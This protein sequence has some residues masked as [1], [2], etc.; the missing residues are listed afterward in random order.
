[1]S[2]SIRRLEEWYARHC[3]GDWEHEDGVDIG[4]LD[5]PGWTVDINIGATELEGVAFDEVVEDRTPDDWIRCR[6][7]GS[8]WQGRGGARNLDEL[9]AIFLAWAEAH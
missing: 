3:D 8:V 9:L 7:E 4:T 1:M 5:N 6:L 2:A